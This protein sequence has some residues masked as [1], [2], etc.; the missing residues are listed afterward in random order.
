MFTANKV[1]K[2][3]FIWLSKIPDSYFLKAI[4]ILGVGLKILIVI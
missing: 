3:A 2:R 4:I 1:Y